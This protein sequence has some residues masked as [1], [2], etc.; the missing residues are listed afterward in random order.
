MSDEKKTTVDLTEEEKRSVFAV[1]KQ[2]DAKAAAE[3]LLGKTVRTKQVR[4]YCCLFADGAN[5]TNAYGI[6]WQEAFMKLLFVH[7]LNGE[8]AKN[9]ELRKAALRPSTCKSTV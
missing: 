4:G 8:S 1:R 5:E 2:S 7:K 6:T 3:K 9:A